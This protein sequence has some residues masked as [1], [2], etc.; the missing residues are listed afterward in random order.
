MFL[1]SGNGIAQHMLGKEQI[2]G[3]SFMKRKSFKILWV[4]LLF[5][6]VMTCS[7][8]KS[9]REETPREELDRMVNEEKSLSDDKKR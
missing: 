1:F 3:G 4:N 8:G 5:L 7:C 6:V 9:V 2:G